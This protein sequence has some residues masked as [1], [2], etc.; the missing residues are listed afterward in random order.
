VVLGIVEDSAHRLFG[1]RISALRRNQMGSVM[2]PRVPDKSG[3]AT[4]S[5]TCDG[6]IL[7]MDLADPTEA[8]ACVRAILPRYL[9]NAG[10]WRVKPLCPSSRDLDLSPPTGWRAIEPG[11][12]FETARQLVRAKHVV[13]A[14]PS[15]VVPG[16]EP[17]DPDLMLADEERRVA[18]PRSGSDGGLVNPD[19]DWSLKLTKVIQ[20]WNVTAP[21]GRQWGDGIVVGHPDTGYTTH[22][23]IWGTE[24]A[25]RR[26]ISG[27]GFDYIEGD[28]DALDVL[29]GS[30]PG[31]GTSTASVI[32][33]DIGTASGGWGGMSGVAPR[34][35]LVPYRVSK[36]VIHFSMKNVTKAIALAA[37]Q[38]H[39]VVS[40]SLGGPFY[41][42]ALRRT[43]RG[44]LD[45]GLI[46]L[47]AAGNVWPWVVY[48][49]AYD[50]VIAVAACDHLGQMWRS[51]ATG[52]AVDVTAPGANVWVASART[53]NP[54]KYRVVPSSGTS[55]AVAH[56][57]GV[58]ALWLAHHDRQ[59]L[60]GRF[61]RKKLATVFRNLLVTSG[62]DTPPDW[63]LGNWGAGIVNAFKLLTAP[64]PSAPVGA[65]KARRAA[66][67]PWAHYFPDLSTDSIG[68]ALGEVLG[69]R[70][71]ALAGLLEQFS[72][73]MAFHIATRPALRH[74]LRDTVARSREAAGGQV[75]RA[76]RRRSQRDFLNAASPSFRRR[77]LGA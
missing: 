23:E 27:L 76:A 26:V 38:G 1:E 74:D 55:F 52:S 17:S 57:A 56:V 30:F 8:V 72:Q 22:P 5:V 50:E 21:G 13:S 75:Q 6:F 53:G 11:E 40:M 20:A 71:K 37:A 35:R 73:E 24:A 51:S 46:L 43:I 49:A 62:V 77:V 10:K 59:K 2:A 47:A 3:R 33:S 28:H 65:P 66:A 36:S 32:M 25:N 39:H 29:D 44:A 54:P 34:A 4:T 31:H 18:L 7:E 48:P 19:H 64:L 61:G 69:V 58:A 60:I 15:F 68:A 16:I 14:E 42:E 67:A 45:E 63:D 12:A 41:S 70:P 9:K